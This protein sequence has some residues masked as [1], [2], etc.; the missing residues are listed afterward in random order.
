MT[1]VFNYLFNQLI[2]TNYRQI[3]V[4]KKGGKVVNET[5]TWD[6]V[7]H[8]TVPMRDKEVVL[9]YRFMPE[10]NL[11]PIYLTTQ[12]N[13]EKD[14]V[15]ISKLAKQ[16]PELPSQ[17]RSRLVMDH[18]L[19]L[20]TALLIVEDSSVLQAFDSI[21]SE[22]KKR[23]SNLV[24]NVLLN[25]V[26]SICNKKKCQIENLNLTHR[27]IGQ[28]IDLLEQ[29]IINQNFT[30]RLL[31]ALNEESVMDTAESIVIKNDWKQILDDV[32][33]EKVCSTILQN[34]Q[35]LVKQFQ[36]GKEKT[37]YALAGLVAKEM[38]GKINMGKATQI[39]RTLLMAK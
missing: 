13:E 38:D 22:N 23:N 27:Q 1:F 14:V 5:R 3:D 39:L 37:F 31:E 26:R 36:K 17:S 8:R 11:L 18:N 12:D 9:D 19:N 35:T 10:P 29:N 15:S 34:N 32:A 4:L 24:A 20:H 16:L 33:I 21:L 30:Q 6:A 28:V 2:L 25:G 7:K